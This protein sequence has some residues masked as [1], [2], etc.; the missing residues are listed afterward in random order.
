[1][2]GTAADTCAYRSA[3]ANLNCILG[4]SEV[5]RNRKDILAGPSLFLC[6]GGLKTEDFNIWDVFLPVLYPSAQ[7]IH[8]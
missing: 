7:E 5:D 3:Y 8:S 6:I 2:E 4:M 1:M